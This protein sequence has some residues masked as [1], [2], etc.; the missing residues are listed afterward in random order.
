MC[1]IHTEVLHMTLW[2]PLCPRD[3]FDPWCWHVWG[4][5]RDC[6]NLGATQLPA[7][8]G[9]DRSAMDSDPLG[10]TGHGPVVSKG[11]K[12][13]NRWKPIKFLGK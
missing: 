2:I 7:S 11:R 4:P 10:A 1:S 8:L 12:H 6:E 13:W 5:P 9:S 3:S